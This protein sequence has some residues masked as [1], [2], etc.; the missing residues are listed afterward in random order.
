[1]HHSIQLCNNKAAQIL[2]YKFLKT[3][4]TDFQLVLSIEF[5]FKVFLKKSQFSLGSSQRNPRYK[6]C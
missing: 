1:M 6:E 2:N 3:N 4:I 5:I